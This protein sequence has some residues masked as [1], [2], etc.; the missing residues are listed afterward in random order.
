MYN[1]TMKAV[2]RGDNRIMRGDRRERGFTLIELLVVV[3]IIGIL[4]VIAL[5]KIQRSFMQAKAAQ[6]VANGETM[7]RAA[8]MYK[9]MQEQLPVIGYGTL[10]SANPPCDQIGVGRW[11]GG[12]QLCDYM[13]AWL[14]AIPENTVC[15]TNKT[16]VWSSDPTQVNDYPSSNDGGFHFNRCYGFMMLNCD[17]FFLDTGKRYY[18]LGQSWKYADRPTTGPCLF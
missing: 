1:S 9:T 6:S 15:G 14:N 12:V 17:G 3:T 13:N 10:Q 5:A 2:T 18:E 4:A 11:A 7:E 8:W 16:F